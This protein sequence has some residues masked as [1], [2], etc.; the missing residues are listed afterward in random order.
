MLWYDDRIHGYEESGNELACVDA[1]MLND[2]LAK[3]RK[4]F[5]E[6]GRLPA[7]DLPPITIDT[8]PGKI[9]AQRSYRVALVKTSAD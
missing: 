1:G 2:V 6:T 8:V 7:A 5:G 9:V 4:V 3:H